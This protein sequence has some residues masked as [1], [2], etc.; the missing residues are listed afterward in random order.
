[1]GD[2]PL[3]ETVSHDT[4]SY[5]EELTWASYR[6]CRR[7]KLSI[8]PKREGEDPPTYLPSTARTKSTFR[9]FTSNG[10]RGTFS[11]FNPPSINSN[12][13]VLVSTYVLLFTP[14]NG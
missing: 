7:C 14:L 4:E 3:R 5:R 13:L 6:K 2:V 8:V 11:R 12:Q 10:P 1:M 9:E